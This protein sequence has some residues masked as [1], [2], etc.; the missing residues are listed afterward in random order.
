MKNFVCTSIQVQI[1][2][3]DCPPGSMYIWLKDLNP[4]SVFGCTPKLLDFEVLLQPFEE[5]LYLPAVLVKFSHLKSSKCTSHWLEIQ[6]LVFVLYPSILQAG[7]ARYSIA[8]DKNQSIRLSHL[9]VH[10]WGVCVSIW[11]IC[12]AGFSLPWQ[13]RMRQSDE[14]YTTS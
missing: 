4:D 2:L 12:I 3:N 14:P 11:W 9:K 1:V 6:T 8:W 13:R 10:S 5:Q 7:T